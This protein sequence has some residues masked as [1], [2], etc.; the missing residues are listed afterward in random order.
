MDWDFICDSDLV[1]EVTFELLPCVDNCPINQVCK[2]PGE[3]GR[4]RSKMESKWQKSGFCNQGLVDR[5][6]S[7]IDRDLDTWQK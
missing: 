1:P 7:S 4:N 2:D 6:L 3:I 5:E